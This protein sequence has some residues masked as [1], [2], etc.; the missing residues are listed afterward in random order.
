MAA[1]SFPFQNVF[2]RRVTCG[3]GHGISVGSLGKSKDEP[4]IG[5]SVVNC[6]LI[7]NMNGV[8]VK[9]W[10]ASMEGLASDM[11]FDDIVMVNVS[12]PVLIDQG[13]CAHNKCNAK[14]YKHDR[15]ILF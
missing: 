10:P 12:N 7:N 11:H 9:T 8:R 1:T 2:V 13:Y 4:V 15:A 5:I 14:S 3:P 6:T